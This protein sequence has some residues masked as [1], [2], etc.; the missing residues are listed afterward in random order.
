MKYNFSFFFLA[1][2]L[3]FST[4]VEAQWVKQTNGLPS[5]WSIG[6]SIDASDSNN[7]II[8]TSVGLFKTTDKG[9]LWTPVQL[10]DSINET[11]ID[12]SMTNTTHYWLAT[13]LGKILATTD[14]GQ[15]WIVQFDDTSKT[16]F[17]N[18][19]EMFDNSNG[20][21][22]GDAP[23]PFQNKPSIFLKTTDGGTNWISYEDA[24]FINVW[25]GDTWR[26]LDF[27]NPM[28][29]Y[30][31]ES[32]INP[33]KLYKTT[34]G[35]INWTA[36]NFADYATV[37]KC[38]D[39]NIILIHSVSNNKISRTIDGGD[40]WDE[41]PLTSSWGN[42]FEFIPVN[43]SKV[44]FT[45]YD[46]L[47][48][49]N[50]TGKTWIEIL[51]DTTELKGRDIVFTDSNNGW[52]LC[53]SGKVYKSSTGGIPTDVDEIDFS[54]PDQFSLS[55]N[56]PNPFNPSTKISWQSPVSGHQTLKVYDVLGKEVAALVNEF[57]YASSYTI[58]FNASSLS[59][60]IYFYKLQAGSFV[61]T[62][63][64]ILIK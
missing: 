63:K 13:D 26:R 47:F 54:V 36:T 56:Y 60:G 17:I 57:R 41:S 25:S 62:K 61:Q 37:L 19:I 42:D 49:S 30:F 40:T 33:Q 16:Q 39:E 29:G 46:K 58:D 51:V 2:Y 22:M 27:V 6:W 32:G 1:V 35:C 8:S 53:D 12:V 43:A 4:L 48:F 7:A 5:S 24:T 55:Q 45:D 9:N 34:D 38:F 15:S 14:A 20:V 28:H 3:L 10:P 59:S 50:D 64:M 21:A 44:F 18:Y 31:Y 11:I 23:F 52:I